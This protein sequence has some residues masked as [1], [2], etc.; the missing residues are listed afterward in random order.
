VSSVNPLR[1]TEVAHP[2]E[3]NAVETLVQLLCESGLS[4]MTE[5]VR[6]MLNE[7]MRTIFCTRDRSLQAHRAPER[8]MPRALSQDFGRA[9]VWTIANIYIQAAFP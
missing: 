5:V 4:Q 2:L 8:D 9:F 7:A 3:S 1:E 6:I